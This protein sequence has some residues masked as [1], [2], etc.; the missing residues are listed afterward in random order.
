MSVNIMTLVVIAANVFGAA[1]ALPQASKLLR[2]RNVDGVSMTWAAVSATVNGWW[3]VY[4]IGVG[5]VSILPVSIVSV[6]AYIVIAVGV[7]R[8]GTVPAGRLLRPAVAATVA[9]AVVPLVAVLL[10]GWATAGIALGALYGIQLC[11]AV[12][13]VY[14]VADVSGVSLATWLIAFAEAVLWGVYGL[15]RLDVGLMTLAVTGTLMSSLV[16]VRLFVR[17]PRRAYQPAGPPGFA[18]A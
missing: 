6:L 11:P 7:V 18:A 2:D 17:R 1:M 14:R 8:F 16:I 12:I 13:A 3:G 4:G 5:D 10:D 9:V 15:A